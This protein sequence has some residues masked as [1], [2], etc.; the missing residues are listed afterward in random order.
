MGLCTDTQHLFVLMWRPEIKVGF[1]PQLTLHLET[2]D[3]FCYA[4]WTVNISVSTPSV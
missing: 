4:G 2:Q 3:L 1:L